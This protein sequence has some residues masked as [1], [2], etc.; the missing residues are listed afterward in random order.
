MISEDELAELDLLDDDPD[1]LGS[2]FDE[3]LAEADLDDE[4]L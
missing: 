2:T 1:D 4:D 3:T